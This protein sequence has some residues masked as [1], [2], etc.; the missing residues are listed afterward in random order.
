MMEKLRIIIAIG[1][2]EQ[3]FTGRNIRGFHGIIAHLNIL[4]QVYIAWMYAFVKT[5]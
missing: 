3:I 2:W 4:T 1:E 5:Q